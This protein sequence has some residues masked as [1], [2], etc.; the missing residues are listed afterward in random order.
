MFWHR[1]NKPIKKCIKIESLHLNKGYIGYDFH[2]VPKNLKYVAK[3]I[4]AINSNLN[5]PVTT[6]FISCNDE[7]AVIEFIGLKDDITEIVNSIILTD[8]TFLDMYSIK[9]I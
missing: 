6:R 8:T 4:D 2:P 1:K 5:N 7:K 9:E 3:C